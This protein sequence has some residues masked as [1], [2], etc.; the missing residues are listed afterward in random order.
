MPNALEASQ[1]EREADL[2]RQAVHRRVSWFVE[3]WTTQLD[4]N[5]RDAAELTADLVVVIQEVHR[6]ASRT[7]HELLRT[8][9]AAMPPPQLIVK[10]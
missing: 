6:D 3:K 2:D 9:L 8:S 10:P 7:T 5:K 4:L 1:V